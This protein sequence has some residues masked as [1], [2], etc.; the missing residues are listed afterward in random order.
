MKIAA[1]GVEAPLT[2]TRR[3]RGRRC[4]EVFAKKHLKCITAVDNVMTAA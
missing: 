3:A 2:L 4:G 1:D